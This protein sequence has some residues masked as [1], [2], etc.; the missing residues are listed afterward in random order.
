MARESDNSRPVPWLIV[1]RRCRNRDSRGGKRPA[2]AREM[3]PAIPGPP[4]TPGCE[5]APRGG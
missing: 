5:P 2:G 1:G 3:T 4:G